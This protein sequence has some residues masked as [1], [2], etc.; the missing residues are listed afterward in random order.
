[1]QEQETVKS[2]LHKLAASNTST[3][4]D[5]ARMQNL[6]RRIDKTNAVVVAGIVYPNGLGQPLDIHTV[7]KRL[8]EIAESK[9]E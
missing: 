7:A 5:S 6:L 3:D 9:E 2:W 8:I 1:M 4:Q